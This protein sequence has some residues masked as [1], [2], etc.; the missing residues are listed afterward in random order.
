MSQARLRLA[1]T[2]SI[3]KVIGTFL[4]Q[5]VFITWLCFVSTPILGVVSLVSFPHCYLLCLHFVRSFHLLILKPPQYAREPGAEVAGG[6]NS[7]A[8]EKIMIY[9]ERMCG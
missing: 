1:R 6:K 3:I 7:L 5:F 4:V 8:K 2:H 9:L